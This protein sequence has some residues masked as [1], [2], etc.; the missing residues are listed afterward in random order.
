MK[1]IVKFFALV[2]TLALAV[3]LAACGK[4]T[5]ISLDATEA[6]LN[7]GET[8]VITATVSDETAVVWTT[9]DAAIATVAGG[10]ITAVA[11]G[12]ATITATAGKVSA[13]VAVTVKALPTLT[14]SATSITVTVGAT[15]EAKATASIADLVISY[16]IADETI[17]TYADGKIKGLKKGSTTLTATLAKFATVTATCTI[18]VVEIAPTEVTITSISPDTFR[19]GDTYQVVANV[20]PADATNKGL[21]YESDDESIATVSQDGLVTAIG[22]GSVVIKVSSSVDADVYSDFDLFVTNA[23]AT[24]LSVAGDATMLST[25]VGDTAKS[26]KATVIPELASQSVTWSSSD[27]SVATIDENGVITPLTY[28]KVTFTAT[29]KDG[30]SLSATFDV[31]IEDGYPYTV[32]TIL[33]DP[34]YTETGKVFMVTGDETVYKI[35]V[36]AFATLAD[37]F[38]AALDGT[39]IKAAA[40]TYADNVSTSHAVSLIGPNDGLAGDDSNRTAGA[41]ITGT[42]TYTAA[43]EGITLAGLDF[44]GAAQVI[45]NAGPSSVVFRDSRVTSS[46]IAV[47]TYSEGRP[48]D[49]TTLNA[50]LS[51]V[52][53]TAAKGLTVTDNYFEVSNYVVSWA[54]YSDVTVSG[55]T[56]KNFAFDAV[57]QDGGYNGGTLSITDNIFANDTLSGYCGIYLRT[58]GAIEGESETI[59]IKSNSFTNIGAD[60]GGTYEAAIGARNYQEYGTVITISDNIFKTCRNYILLRNNMT[61][62]NYTAYIHTLTI[63][64]NSFFGAPVGAYFMNLTSASDTSSSNPCYATM[65]SNLFADENGAGITVDFTSKKLFNALA[66]APTNSFNSIAGKFNA[67]HNLDAAA[68][69]LFV[70]DDF[71]GNTGDAVSYQGMALVMGTNAF[72]TYADAETAAVAGSII[73]ICPGDITDQITITKAGVIVDGNNTG[74][75]P[76]TSLESLKAATIMEQPIIVAADGVTV[77]GFTFMIPDTW[78]AISMGGAGTANVTIKNLYLPT[79]RTANIPTSDYAAS[80]APFQ[81][82]IDADNK[83]KAVYTDT[84]I[85]QCLI[86]AR[87]GRPMYLFGANINGLQLVDN[88]FNGTLGSGTFNDGLKISV[89]TGDLY[90]IGG[91][92]VFS[93][94]YIANYQQY[95]VWLKGIAD[96]AKFLFINNTYYNCQDAS[97]AYN[98]GCVTISDV[99]SGCDNFTFY[100]VYNTITQGE[101]LIDYRNLPITQDNLNM[102]IAFNS[103]TDIATDAA[104]G[105]IRNMDADVTITA[106]SNYF[107]AADPS[108]LNT[109]LYV[110]ENNYSDADAYKTALTADKAAN[111]MNYIKLFM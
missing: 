38:K 70:N 40:G 12:S 7:V 69:P 62:A 3:T 24:S 85:M 108:T 66:A 103:Y 81:F 71:S 48:T 45:A 2:L 88:S 52:A 106:S 26:L 21:V 14:F 9:S 37:A 51:V 101:W 107:D 47:S 16:K 104:G 95:V 15:K 98:H 43:S 99:A 79:G 68:A 82:V 13:T 110:L 78:I 86:E 90:G 65:D 39:T 102:L 76:V 58:Y 55:N 46:T 74:I 105:I 100:F 23:L 29:T 27:G 1:R 31:T 44:Q 6:S 4:K 87:K 53:P 30:T 96:D 34:A 61:S 25:D 19:V 75:N 41:V 77:D 67:E 59:D 83:G 63:D 20:E 22:L 36:N 8:K 94:N 11:T 84:L 42:I 109:G 73:F 49:F 18:R 111:M 17:A 93:G 57:R 35:G 33:L 72:A 5:T 56:F 28:G 91:K 50:F 10:T 97:D 89:A 54:R 32:T 92:V 60:N 64:G 80:E